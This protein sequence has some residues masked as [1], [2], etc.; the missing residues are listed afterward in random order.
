MLQ[1][2]YKYIVE[3]LIAGYFKE[4]PLA[5]GSRYYLII[6]NPEY[7]EGLVEAFQNASTPITISDI[8]S[9]G[10]S[11]IEEESYETCYLQPTANGPRLILGYDQ[12]A[13]EDY[14]TTMR[15]AIGVSG[16]KYE[17]D[18][19]LYILSDSGLSSLI[20][21][22][23]NLQGENAPLH[24]KV[25]IDNIYGKAESKIAKSYELLYLK[26]YLEKI[27][28][29]I[30]D[31][32]CDL[33][34]FQHA[35]AIL[36]TGELK[37]RFTDLGFFED[38]NIYE[39]SFAIPEDD[40]EQ[41]IAQNQQLYQ[42]VEGIMHMDEETNKQELLQKRLDE[43]LSKKIDKAGNDWP[44]QVT[45][46]QVLES[47]DV[48]D[49][50]ANFEL[51]D[52]VL[53]NEGPLVSMIYRQKGS[54]KKS[55]NYIIICDQSAAP[56]QPLKLRFNKNVKGATENG[57]KIQGAD[58]TLNVKDEFIKQRVGILDNRHDFF[59]WRIPVSGNFFTEVKDFMSI[60]KKGVIVV[61]VPENC[62]T[63]TFGSSAVKQGL[64]LS[65]KVAWDGSF[66]LEIR[67]DDYE[68]E[69]KVEFELSVDGHEYT[70]LLK[71][72]AS[73]PLPPAGPE[74]VES[75]VWDEKRT[76]QGIY[77]DDSGFYKIVCND[78]E[79]ATIREWRKF[80]DWENTFVCENT[81]FVRSEY[82]KLTQK[83]SYKP[84]FLNLPATVKQAL[85]EI[86]AYYRKKS[87]V[88]SL[89]YIDDELRTL[90][91]AYCMSVIKVIK[92]IST[93]R[94][95]SEQE[96]ALT[97]LGVVEDWK[98]VY[99]SPFHPLLVAYMLEFKEKYDKED[100]QTNALR[101]LS[102]FYL[103][104]YLS[105]ND[106]DKRPYTDS[107][108]ERMRNWLCYEGVNSEPQERINN[109]TQ[110][111]VE[112]KMTQFLTHFDY[113][114][115]DTESPIIINTIGIGNDVNVIKGIVEFIKKSYGGKGVV[116]H[117]ELHEYVDDLMDETFFEKLNRLCALDAIV[118]EFE[119]VGIKLEQKDSYSAQEIVHQLFTRVAFY[120]H[121]LAPHGNGLNYCHIAFYQMD[122]GITFITPNTEDLR[123]E[124]SLDGLIS[125][126]STS[127]MNDSYYIG[128]GTRGLDES[129]SGFVYPM[130]VCM[131]MLYANEKNNGTSLFH[132]ST[133]LVKRYKFEG[134]SLVDSIFDHSNWVTF[135]NPEVDI[136][137]FYKRN[138]YVIHYTDQYTINAKYDSITATKH[139]DQY[140][141]MLRKS[142]EKY[143]LSNEFFSHF[144]DTM[145]KYFN[146]LNGSWML[147]VVNKPEPQIL[148]KMS[149]VAASI[150]MQKFMSRVSGVIWIPV[151]LEE[152][153]RVTRSIGLSE[154]Y[155]FT[156]KV[157][158][159]KGAMSDDLLMI[160]LDATVAGQVKMYMYPVEVKRSKS[161]AFT[162][163]GLAQ[164]AQTFRQ[165]REHIFGK[166]NFMK[167]IYRT[168]FASQMLTNADK[169]HANGL[170]E[171]S[172]YEQIVSHRYDLL[173][174]GFS[175][176]EAM[177]VPEMGHAALVS[178]FSA[179]THDMETV[180]EDNVAICQIH[181][182]EQEAFSFVANPNSYHMQFLKDDAIKI[183]PDVLDH[184]LNVK[185]GMAPSSQNREEEISV[186]IITED[187]LPKTDQEEVS[188]PQPS[189]T[190]KP[191]MAAEPQIMLSGVK[192]L[193]GYEDGSDKDIFFEPNNTKKVSHPN[194][195]I[196]GTMG[197][198]KTQFARSVIAQLSKEA[199]HN[200]DGSP[201]GV[202]VFDYKGDY[203][204]EDFLDAVNGHS[205][206]CNYPFNPLKL[207]V[208]NDVVGM[209]LPAITADRISDSF[210]KAY[211][212]GL[213]QQ[214]NIKQVI[215]DT[216]ADKGITKNPDTWGYTVPTMD[217]V[218]EKYFSTYD[219]NDKA[220][221][222]FDKL[223]DYSIFTTDNS[224]CVS[225]F[226]WL[227]G[228]RVID[229]TLYP[230]DTKKVI[231]SLI[232][233]LFYA[234]MRQLG[235]SR[236]ENG[237]R[238]LRSFIMVD[239]AHQ[240]LKKDFNSLR[241]I[242]SEGRMFGVGIILSTQNVADFKTSAE[243][244]SQYVLSWVIH[245]VNSISK[246]EISNIFGASDG[247][248]DKYMHFINRAGLFESICK[249]GGSVYGMK[250]LPFF[251]LKDVDE[252]FAEKKDE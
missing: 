197:T 66:A 119:A 111:M 60:S 93:E 10:D 7:R 182:P 207:I 104:P 115:P 170:L 29:Y 144:N 209:N 200:V 108:L 45:L 103:I 64:P 68:D 81:Y 9:G 250:D 228:V 240:F 248:G 190:V 173:N 57:A 183:A 214:S 36:Q 211:G 130:A 224:Q 13:T 160:G 88:P 42:W 147:N 171:H 41:R 142:Y 1:S 83:V 30:A 210:A 25:I 112:S 40:M 243:D 188:V 185:H 109:V 193:V 230:D 90:Y 212:L 206:K 249:L 205:Y 117:I 77:G 215:I 4:H 128:F 155:I 70:I 161:S 165:L 86:Y 26:K 39:S 237:Y 32:T 71:L 99:L 139:V 3:E 37:G 231:V 196:I 195:G 43:R 85:D 116:Q 35:L 186:S 107:F 177:P 236:Q 89:T 184:V 125:I 49:S 138:L 226:E 11:C 18:S 105:Y 97:K 154:D 79:R 21:A 238:E 28:A 134:E 27:A 199:C 133:A 145:M 69:D 22:S 217:D 234:E 220:Y 252:R 225:L 181:F 140:K 223:R 62:E 176:G 75:K 146:C 162:K 180:L 232:L 82:N 208:N 198:G 65:G 51:L 192:I 72:C 141:N 19:L 221:A 50:T 23:R 129:R 179:A 132:K 202:L 20:T 189:T 229:L 14:L 239:E 92:A 227:D 16:S 120:K 31:G 150:A 167:K 61:D 241:N 73:K 15:N 46:Q 156:K 151:S 166:D 113:L 194:L 213:K 102:P 118:R 95:M 101:L 172:A 245:H 76:F 163:K 80:L 131:N 121:K 122:T 126:P 157:L 38:R 91:S 34:D 127:F 233:D 12:T 44:C 84:E 247:N 169:L 63:V 59:V 106:G 55:D 174:T 246:S 159:V 17:N 67:I 87:S 53:P 191:P 78:E 56:E 187:D 24:S 137:F 110:K 222:L 33:F 123:V 124:M 204:D 48:H 47:K 135:L 242:I 149:V 114:F 52:M 216:Y 203:K 148:E 251:R 5:C 6:E 96:Y 218:I 152:I 8:Y 74:Y 219:S 201:I 136:D 143:A 164:V 244:Y 100:K 58:V 175:L 178:F 168:F 94:G 235:G 158:N 153:L 2:F 54:K 98:Q